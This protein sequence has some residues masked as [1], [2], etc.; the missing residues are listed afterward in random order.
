MKKRNWSNIKELAYYSS[1]GL[2]VALSVLI[3]FGIGHY[4]DSEFETEPWLTIIFFILGV[5]AAGR[6][7]GLAI[8]KLRKF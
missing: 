2:Q 1:L 6:N 4:L 5:A 7:I 8:R 3:G